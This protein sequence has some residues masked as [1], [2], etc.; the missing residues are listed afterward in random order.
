MTYI[1]IYNRCLNLNVYDARVAFLGPLVVRRIFGYITA[2][3]DGVQSLIQLH[4]PS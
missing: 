3:R 2:A 1:Y 4:I